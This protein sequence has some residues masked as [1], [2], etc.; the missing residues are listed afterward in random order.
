MVKQ[1]ALAFVKWTLERYHQFE[2]T[3]KSCFGEPLFKDLFL[4]ASSQHSIVKKS[5]GL[6]ADS[7]KPYASPLSLEA[8]PGSSLISGLHNFMS[9][10][11]YIS[12]VSACSL[13]YL[14][15]ILYTLSLPDIYCL[16]F[17][18]LLSAHARF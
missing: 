9:F 16:F 8:T 17:F 3:G 4:T 18:L 14:D 13:T 7:S 5:D 2:D 10:V 1:A 6:E 12:V 15:N 11:F